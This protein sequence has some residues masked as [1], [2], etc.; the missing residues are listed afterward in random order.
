MD[1]CIST[2]ALGEE[3]ISPALLDRLLAAGFTQIEMFANRPHW[4]YHDRGLGKNLA[5]W[6]QANDVET[7]FLHLPF[8]EQKGRGDVRWISALSDNERDRERAIDEIKRALEFTDLQPVA[9]VVAHLG[10]PNQRFSPLQFEHA[11][12][13][14]RHIS[15]F[16]G[17]DTLIENIGNE[18][19]TMERLREFLA[20]AQLP[21]IRICYDTG[22][23]LLQ[24]PLP[25]LDG[26]AAIHLSD[27]N[28][29]SD[30]HL[31]PFEGELNWPEFVTELVR[32]GFEGPM[33]FEPSNPPDLEPGQAAARRLEALIAEAHSSSIEFAKKYGMESKND[34]NDLH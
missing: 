13:L 7:P 16:A 25:R 31:W 21:E 2:H 11:Y 14:M 1:F 23:G 10:S 8:F 3:E 26:V 12:S 4:D 19:S 22:H 33:V 29:G 24:G 15:E 5:R 27:N 32:S 17:V 6:F 18:I 20:L 9:H 28:G 30:D 34:D